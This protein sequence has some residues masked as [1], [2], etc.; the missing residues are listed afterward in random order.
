MTLSRIVAPAALAALTAFGLGAPT[1][2]HAGGVSVR[3]SPVKVGVKVGPVT[4][5]GVIGATPAPAPR[6][7]PHAVWVPAHYVWD[8]VKRREIYVAGAWKVPPRP[9]MRY[10]TGHWV[11]HGRSRHW[12]AGY[13]R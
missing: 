9:G 13:W 1:D 5:G 2:A 10:V 11:G 3:V 8:P 12:V 4:I 6:I 7:H